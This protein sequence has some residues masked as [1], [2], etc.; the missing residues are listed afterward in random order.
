M[1]DR[2]SGSVMTLQRNFPLMLYRLLFS[3]LLDSKVE[4]YLE[5][6]QNGVVIYNPLGSFDSIRLCYEI[7]LT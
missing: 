1:S 5:R 2:I 7:F 4:E 6:R 3:L